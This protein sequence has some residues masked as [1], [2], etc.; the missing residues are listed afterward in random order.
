MSH[1]EWEPLT[2]IKLR[3][4][5]SWASLLLCSNGHYVK[6]EKKSHSLEKTVIPGQVEMEPSVI[7][8]TFFLRMH[9]AI[10]RFSF[11]LLF[12][13]LEN[14][15]DFASVWVCHALLTDV[16]MLRLKRKKL[17]PFTS[18]RSLLSTQP[19]SQGLLFRS[20]GAGERKTRPEK[21]KETT[22]KQSG[23]R[24]KLSLVRCFL[25]HSCSPENQNESTR[26]AY[27]WLSHTL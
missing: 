22:Q 24:F 14:R 5:E 20:P 12:N 19:R 2:K 18:F 11:V 3:A 7:V 1:R 27:L 21:W 8:K 6:K 17:K 16:E 13:F 25:N 15:R 10:L 26:S 23:F 9:G 4:P